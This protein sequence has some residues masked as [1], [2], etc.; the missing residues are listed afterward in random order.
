MEK[1]QSTRSSAATPSA[2]GERRALIG[3]L[4]QYKVAAALVLA[5][6][7]RRELEFIELTNDGNAA[8]DDLVIATASRID[9]YQVK[10]REHPE[11]F[12]FN[13]LKASN[14]NCE[15]QIRDLFEGH[16]AISRRFPHRRVVV[17]LYTCD[18]PST[19]DNCRPATAPPKLTF[20]K[21]LD[22]VWYPAHRGDRSGVLLEPDAWAELRSAAK[23]E[24]D[25]FAKFVT[26][27]NLSFGAHLASPDDNSRDS[28]LRKDQETELG[29]FLMELAID[30]EHSHHFDVTTLLERLNWSH[31]FRFRHRHE[32]AVADTYER[33]VVTADR[34]SEAL[35]QLPGGYVFLGGTPG[36]GKSSLLTRTFEQRSTT[37]RWIRYYAFV[38][39]SH[40]PGNARGETENFLHDV[41]TALEKAGVLSGQSRSDFNRQQL[42][43]RLDTQLQRLGDDFKTGDRRTVILIDGLDHIPRE[44]N[45]QVS[46]LVDLPHPNRVPNGVFILLGSQTDQLEG[47]PPTVKA[48]VAEPRRRILM[49]PLTPANVDH[50]VSK[51]EL[52]FQ[53]GAAQRRQMF[54]LSQGHPLAVSLLLNH[55]RD[56]RDASAAGNIL[57]SAEPYEGDIDKVYFSYW[58]SL[59]QDAELVHLLAVVARLRRHIDLAWLHTFAPHAALGAL[60]RTLQHLF[61]RETDS[62]W[63]FFHNSFRLFLRRNTATLV[64]EPAS[65]NEQKLHS[66]LAEQ[67][68][69]APPASPWAWEALFH[70]AEAGEHHKVAQLANSESFRRQLLDFRP[71]DAIRSDVKRSIRSAGAIH[72]T[73]A[74][75][76]LVLCAAE[77]DQRS[78]GL[79]TGPVANLLMKLG[80]FDLA[81]EHLFDGRELRIS[82]TDALRSSRLLLGTGRHSESRKL[83]ELAEPT[84]EPVSSEGPDA[85]TSQTMLEEWVRTASLFRPLAD[86]LDV[87]DKVKCDAGRFNKVSSEDA[88]LALKDRLVYYLSVQL[89]ENEDASSA[90]IVE[91]LLASDARRHQLWFWAKARQWR[92]A[93]AIGNAP[94]ATDLI[95]STLAGISTQSLSSDELAVVAEGLYRTTGSSPETLRF[96]DKL[97]Q[98]AAV[99]NYLRYEDVLSA[100]LPRFR[101]NR[102]LRAIGRDSEP[103]TLIPTTTNF[104][105]EGLVFYERAVTR[106]SF[107]WGDAWRGRHY[108]PVDVKLQAGGILRLFDRTS[109]ER[110]RWTSWDGLYTND[111]ELFALL[112]EAIAQHGSEAIDAL[113]DLFEAE[114]TSGRKGVW[115][116]ATRRKVSMKFY[117]FGVAKEWVAAQLG[118]IE[119]FMLI[120]HDITG[121]INESREQSE[122]YSR[123]REFGRA[124]HWLHEMLRTSFGVGYRKDYQ[125]DSWIE[126]LPAISKLDPSGSGR[127]IAWFA[128]AAKDLEAAT[129]GRSAIT[130]A[131]RLI[132]VAG[133]WNTQGVVRLVR[134]FKDH[135]PLA[136]ESSLVS[137]LTALIDSN[138][139]SPEMASG[140]VGDLLFRFATEADDDLSEK[141][142]THSARVR[143]KDF[144][145]SVA[146]TV[147]RKA[148]LYG[149]PSTRYGWLGGLR[150]GLTKARIG[151]TLE[152]PVPVDGPKQYPEQDYG[153]VNLDDGTTL[154]EEEV[155]SHCSS[156]AA[157]VTLKARAN[158]TYFR[159]GKVVARLAP[160]LTLLEIP[161]LVAAVAS[162]S[163]QSH[164]LSLLSRRATE[165]GSRTLGWQLGT[166]ALAAS[167]DYGWTPWNDGGS[168]IAASQALIEANP[169][170][171]R[172]LCV[173][174]F[175][176]D[177]SKPSSGPFGVVQ[178]LLD[179]LPL[180][181]D[182]PPIGELWTLV[183][184]YLFSLCPNLAS[185][186]KPDLENVDADDTTDLFVATLVADDLCGPI[187]QLAVGAQHCFGDLLAQGH[188]GATACVRDLLFSGDD[189]K[190]LPAICLV[191]SAARKDAKVVHSF[192]VE[193][194]SLIDHGNLCVW[195]AARDLL[196]GAGESSL[197]DRPDKELPSVYKLE[198]PNNFSAQTV[199]LME[200]RDGEP[201]P[202]PVGLFDMLVPFDMQLR[203]VAELF[204]RE[205][206]P[207]LIRACSLMKSLFDESEWSS[208]AEREVRRRLT[209]AGLEYTFRRPRG[210][211]ARTAMFHALS[212]LVDCGAMNERA[213]RS[214]YES[215]CP[216]DHSLMLAMPSL[217]PTE[218]AE[219]G[220]ADPQG[221]HRPAWVDQFR[222][223]DIRFTASV[224]HTVVIAEM[225]KLR[226][227]QWEL[228]SLTIVSGIAT[229]FTDRIEDVWDEYNFLT[230]DKYA[231]VSGFEPSTN[232]FIV[233][234]AE[235]R[236]SDCEQWL[237]LS[238]GVG[239]LLGWHLSGQGL[240]RWV[241]GNGAIRAET[242]W[243]KDSYL[244][245]RPP[246]LEDEVG[247]GC[248]VCLSPAGLSEL[249][250]TFPVLH[251]CVKNRRRLTQD[252]LP[253][254]RSLVV[255]RDLPA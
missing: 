73:V 201:L 125:L 84:S 110:I 92:S 236:D 89:W 142:I 29:Y 107:V 131:K 55:L 144:A 134:W 180:L 151:K 108:S 112:I 177:M 9:A 118:A 21:F 18:Y 77:F 61:Y 101:I 53:L 167:R 58:H 207:L 136:Y 69:K 17:H 247:E 200:L 226:R 239:K 4:P 248:I 72:D 45:P 202:D 169:V 229:V 192:R 224:G 175:V 44:Q 209:N 94:A 36:S 37:E 34:L 141:L 106:I 230:V 237:A 38:P 234:C 109:R 115:R 191:R 231:T 219:M 20:A 81:I 25:V 253:H 8:V 33:I 19:N 60:K 85:I 244:S 187:K 168:R 54:S 28:V 137:A 182:S 225:T 220:G 130:A 153:T 198:F 154:K 122:A 245:H 46:L 174:T 165:L 27:C 252:G 211:A 103:T 184:D 126:W 41:T 74:V 35:E 56:A 43:S 49:E 13:R 196:R 243:W 42:I 96:I 102:L 150:K 12:T 161:Q 127:R 87:V 90:A 5:A 143:G 148:C 114:W 40:D 238:P 123:L 66:S 249:R 216:Y 7:R 135:G 111:H 172:R 93:I 59:E 26:D 86:I 166:D 217:R 129:E 70:H 80:K 213:C 14:G 133:A 30:R 71:L 121:R 158:D 222:Q 32:F 157:F 146:D 68:E 50:V 162:M 128:A 23:A 179:L 240:F 178:H 48:A 140:V 254:D 39:G 10:W 63:F 233:K 100:F 116:S 193:L 205:P 171:G 170:E 195:I 47:I 97:K 78:H 246:K 119:P 138:R 181:F 145:A 232:S 3:L 204:G 79:E 113:K 147:A 251:R 95:R 188:P 156:V 83:F 62:R 149:L 159:W 22:R 176:N 64:A 15:N 88:T 51:A 228:P 173:D 105:Q 241:D 250:S 194:R 117:D 255:C 203:W 206:E 185:L 160:T 139:I 190:V 218:V 104:E 152:D 163:D 1:K 189:A 227:L 155:V 99:S 212:E 2:A 6:M 242:L 91:Q 164:S 199:R 186:P 210:Q 11:A 24:D 16:R 57:D 183:E 76:R 214:V 75:V 208:D 67:C 65:A 124:E 223:D 235:G 98:P 120:G 31:F 215:L 82:N 132:S 197:P 221:R 52:P